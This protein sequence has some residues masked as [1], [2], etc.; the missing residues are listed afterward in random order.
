[1][2]NK[3][4]AGRTTA[5]W[6]VRSDDRV[7]VRELLRRKMLR[8]ELARRGNPAADAVYPFRRES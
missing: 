6:S 7:N 3:M 8:K 2:D 5:A 1:M 4:K